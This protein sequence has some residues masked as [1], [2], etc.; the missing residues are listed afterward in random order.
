MKEKQ[1]TMSLELAKSMFVKDEA[2][3]MLIKK[4][5]SNEDLG[6]KPKLPKK[7]ENLGIV[8]GFYIESNSEI[9]LT[10][11]GATTFG[12]YKNVLPTK[13]LAEAML[14]MCQLLYLRDIYNDGWVPNWKC[15]LTGKCA[16][17]NRESQLY[18]ANSIIVS[19]P[20]IFKTSELRDEFLTNFRDLLEIAKPLL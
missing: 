2:M 14:A 7:W 5:F 3:D 13:E 6:I 12:E 19:H 11:G 18:I 4:H 10:Y 15:D 8:K 20:M 17:I 9:S 16:I 1:I